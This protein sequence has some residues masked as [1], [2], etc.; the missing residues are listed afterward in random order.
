MHTAPHRLH[1][2]AVER[3]DY[4]ITLEQAGEATF[5]HSDVVR[6]S[7]A[8]RRQFC[9][10]LDALCALRQ[11]PLFVWMQPEN[12]KLHRFCLD[13]GFVDAGSVGE[14]RLMK[15]GGQ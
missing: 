15:R 7:S 1:V 6:W 8:V 13:V 2:V 12:R 14:Y 3:D 11:S 10:D 5:A 9:A 4:R